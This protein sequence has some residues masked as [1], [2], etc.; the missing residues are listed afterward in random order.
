MSIP[1]GKELSTPFC[2]SSLTK[3]KR[4]PNFARLQKE[5]AEGQL[6]KVAIIPLWI[7][8]PPQPL[9]G[10]CQC[11]LKNGT[12][13]YTHSQA[14]ASHSRLVFSFRATEHTNELDQVLL[15]RASQRHFVLFQLWTPRLS[16]LPTELL[17][18]FIPGHRQ[19]NT[20]TDEASSS[21]GSLYYRVLN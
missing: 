9:P 7:P 21:K 20:P 1:S 14:V 13:P 17:K 12:L 18:L 3:G 16:P 8:P 4:D 5:G 2:V 6:F 11:F 19:K 10:N 15:G